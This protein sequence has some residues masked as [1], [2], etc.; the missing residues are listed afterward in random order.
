MYLHAGGAGINTGRF[1]WIYGQTNSELMSLTYDGKLGLGIT[2][3]TT[4]LH[5]VGTS[6]VTGNA[7]FGGNVTVDGN[8]TGNFTLQ[9]IINSNVSVTTGISTF[10]T[11]TT[12]NI[13]INSTSPS[14]AVDAQGSTGLFGKIGVATDGFTSSESFNVNGTALFDSVGVGTTALVT[15]GTFGEIQLFDKIIEM[16]G[17]FLN[18][19]NDSHIGFNTF[20]PRSVFDFG[21]VG[22]ATTNP[23][24]IMP[25]ITTATRTGLGATVEGSIIF[26]TSTKKFQGY[27]GTAWVD[28]H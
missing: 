16:N 9:D 23:Y 21:N 3:P 28:L 4:D 26:N 13:G 27:T 7:W 25:T 14:V 1:D 20:S 18:V 24:M 12:T 8:L 5:V 10:S 6:T 22:S 17:G 15:S 11:I 2:N 19:K